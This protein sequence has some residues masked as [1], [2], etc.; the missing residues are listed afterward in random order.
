MVIRSKEVRPIN[1]EEDIQQVRTS[2]KRIVSLL[3]FSTINQTKVVTAAS[4]LARNVYEH[5]KGGEVTLEI[6]DEEQRVGLKMTFVDHGPGIA[7]INQSM[8]DG[9][10]TGK[11]MGLGLGGSK[12]LMDHF[13]IDSEVGKGTTI[14]VIK[15]NIKR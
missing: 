6:D 14:Q 13:F 7:N 5:G 2:V 4:E 8:E 15:W 10:T 11:G 9:F 1:T 12:R 3:N